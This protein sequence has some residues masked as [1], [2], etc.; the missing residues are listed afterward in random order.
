[1]TVLPESMEIQLN[2][3][4]VNLTPRGED[5][6]MERYGFR[7]DEDPIYDHGIMQTESDL[8]FN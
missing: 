2:Q 6:G 5:P 1:M 4:S 7:F 8:Y 3:Y